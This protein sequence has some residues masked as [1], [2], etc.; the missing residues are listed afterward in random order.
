MVSMR[1]F[2]RKN[3]FDYEAAF[4]FPGFFLELE[5]PGTLLRRSSSF[6]ERLKNAVLPGHKSSLFSTGI[7]SSPI[8][9]IFL[10]FSRMSKLPTM[11]FSCC[12]VLTAIA[13]S[14]YLSHPDDRTSI[15]TS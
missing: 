15:A 6:Y 10:V 13:N 3:C 8:R 14:P 7:I 2:A 12:S 1:L 5:T 11:E 4:A 9:K